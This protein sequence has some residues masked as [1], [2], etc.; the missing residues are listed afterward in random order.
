MTRP[1]LCVICGAR[2]T[3]K[4]C[5]TCRGTPILEQRYI[6]RDVIGRGAASLYRADD[7]ESGEVVAVK[8]CTRS[9]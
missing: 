6:L 9:P 1:L 3:D 4:S 2:G 8:K 5:A 7:T